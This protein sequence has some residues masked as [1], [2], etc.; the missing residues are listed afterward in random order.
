MYV[1]I[2]LGFFFQTTHTHILGQIGF[3]YLITL[4]LREK[5]NTK[6]ELGYLGKRMKNGLEVQNMEPQSA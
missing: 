4:I 3:N 6:W 2:V 5:Q 1:T